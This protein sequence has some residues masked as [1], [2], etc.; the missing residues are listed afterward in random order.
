MV[1]QHD[2]PQTPPPSTDTLSFQHSQS[3]TASSPRYRATDRLLR[4]QSGSLPAIDPHTF[5]QNPGRSNATN[6][7]NGQPVLSTFQASAGNLQSTRISQQ[8]TAIPQS[9]GIARQGN[10]SPYAGLRPLA[11]GTLLR[12]NRYQLQELQERQDWLSE[13]YEATWIGRDA[14]RNGG[15]VMICE[16]AL[17]ES[18]S[19]VTQTLLR[20]ATMSLANVGRHRHIAALWDAFSDHGRS[21]FIFEPTEGDSLYMRMRYSGRPLPEQEVIECCLQMTEV[22]ELLA[23]QSPNLVHGLIRPEHIFIGRS[24]AQYFLTNFSV[25]LAGGGTQFVAGVDRARLSPYTTPEFARGVIDTRTDLYALIATAYHAVTGTVLT[26]ISGNIPQARRI[27][28]AISQE[29]ENILTKGLRSVANQRYQRSSELRQDLLA[30][31]SVSGTLV[32]SDD[33]S[34]N[35]A[36]SFRLGERDAQVMM[37]SDRQRLEQMPVRQAAAPQSQVL[38]IK[39][40][41]DEA[42]EERAVLLPKPEELPQMPGSNDRLNAV[43]LLS[44]ILV[45]LIVLIVMT[46]TFS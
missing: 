3:R 29:F 6:A 14:Q 20:T 39:M 32:S 38:P 41:I 37:G 13:V 36:R 30:L 18:S 44:F 5:P 42:E 9:N 40:V 26:G 10:A 21:F 17:P 33:A 31:R 28:S 1:S 22:L 25:V 35:G 11:P 19:V 24:N 8:A 16:V 7:S 15:Q 2:F 4:N 45:A 46:Q 27:N 43:L 12:G 34:G 23:Q